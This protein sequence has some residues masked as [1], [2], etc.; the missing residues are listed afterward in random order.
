MCNNHA[1]HF[2]CL[3]PACS[4]HVMAVVAVA[5][6]VAVVVAAAAIAAAYC[7]CC[8]CCCCCCCCC[9]C[10]CCCCVCCRCVCCRCCCCCWHNYC[11]CCCRCWCCYPSPLLLLLLLHRPCQDVR[12]SST[13]M[14]WDRGVGCVDTLQGVQRSRKGS[15]QTEP[16]KGCGHR[17]CKGSRKPRKG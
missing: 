4:S 6:T 13:T 17:P 9:C 14:T 3:C 5:I 12:R 11:W 16:R 1:G 10:S 8:F 15:V 2:R 7:C